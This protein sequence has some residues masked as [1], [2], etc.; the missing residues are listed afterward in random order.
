[1]GLAAPAQK[2]WWQC[3]GAVVGALAE[4]AALSLDNKSK[5]NLNADT[6]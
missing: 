6:K 1:M 2:L 5:N 3:K 4:L